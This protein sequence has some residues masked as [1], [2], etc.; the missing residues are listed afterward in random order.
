MARHGPGGQVQGPRSLGLHGD[1]P[2]QG[3]DSVLYG[4]Q[5]RVRLVVLLADPGQVGAVT[6]VVP[7]VQ[8]VAVEAVHAVPG[9]GLVLAE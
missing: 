7:H 1:S 9:H 4:V 6:L 8:E 5:L 3:G 2:V